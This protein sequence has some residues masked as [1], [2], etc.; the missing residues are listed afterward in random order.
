MKKT[1]I[2]P[3]CEIVIVDR[4]DIITESPATVIDMWGEEITAEDV[5]ID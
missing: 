3:A 1:Y 5:V 4:D 2:S